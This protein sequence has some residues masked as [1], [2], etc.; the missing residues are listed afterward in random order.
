[1]SIVDGQKRRYIHEGDILFKRVEDFRRISN[2]HIEVKYFIKIYIPHI[3]KRAARSRGAVL[4]RP[5][6]KRKYRDA[7][8][9]EFPVF[10]L[11]CPI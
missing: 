1:M 7:I 10:S 5:Q 3:S 6:P 4:A 8:D 2:I 9:T 11:F